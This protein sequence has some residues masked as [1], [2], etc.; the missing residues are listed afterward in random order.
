MRPTGDRLTAAVR[1]MTRKYDVLFANN[2]NDP[3]LTH[4]AYWCEDRLHLNATGHRRVAARV[5]QTMGEPHPEEWMTSLPRATAAPNLVQNITYYRRYVLPWI[6][7]RLTGRS[8][9]DG[10]QPKY[11]QWR[12]VGPPAVG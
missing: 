6:G 5:L 12:T 1:E 3:E 4:A 2:W 7:R 8:S 11:A 10:R 9:G